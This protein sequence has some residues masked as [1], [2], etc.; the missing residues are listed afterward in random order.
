VLLGVAGLA[1]VF[2]V[3]TA[4]R[5]GHPGHPRERRMWVQAVTA[6]AFVAALLLMG[7]VAREITNR[8]AE[9]PASA[10]GE[11]AEPASDQAAG[12]TLA[13]GLLLALVA[14]LVVVSGRRAA[15]RSVLPDEELPTAA[16]AVSDVLDAAIDDV[17][18]DPDPR[19][20]VI[21]AYHRTE[22]TLAFHGLGRRPSEAPFEYLTRAL[23]GL[24]ASGPSIRRLTALFQWAM[25]SLHPIDDTM[26]SEAIAALVAV[27]DDLRAR[28]GLT[29][30]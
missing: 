24:S 25:F 11:P 5:G 16:Q 3:V 26:K 7:K 19:R 10:L 23:A 6:L 14:V 15:R 27:R 9:P 29:A 18:A 8:S 17:W 22:H 21:L 2:L 4:F 13:L 12:D 1:L 28:A 30:S 20:A